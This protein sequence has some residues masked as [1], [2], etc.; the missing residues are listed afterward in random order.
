M[1]R[2][3]PLV[4]N[5]VSKKGGASP[6]FR[7]GPYDMDQGITMDGGRFT[8]DIQ[9]YMLTEW[10]EQ[11]PQLNA[12]IDQVYTTE[13]ARIV[14]KNFEVLGTNASDDDVTFASTVG[15]IQIQ[16]DGA[17]N[18]QVI[19]LPHL[20][21]NQTAWTGVLWGT[22]NQVVWEAIIRTGAS[23]SDIIIWAGLKL[24]NTSTVATD[25]DQAF[26][27]FDAGVANWEAT[28]SI[29]G[30]DTEQDTGVAVSASTNYYLRIEVDS[31][32]KA[33]FFI[34]DDEVHVS[35]ALTNDVDLIPY[36]GVQ[37]NGA[38]AAKTLNIVRQSISRIIF[39]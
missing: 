26:F 3:E 6:P 31:D 39:E 21:T 11:I 25:A 30:T 23:V 33:H 37:A 12:T 29:G 35:S 17:D 28:Y 10:F 15:G 20:D 14:N 8:K 38:A 16:T 7:N 1:Y 27:R 9:R 5:N 2:D 4:C 34:N 18:D 13:A 22:E 32:R 24:T 19:V 36:I